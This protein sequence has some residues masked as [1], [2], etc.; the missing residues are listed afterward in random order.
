MAKKKVTKIVALRDVLDKQFYDLK[1]G[2]FSLFA[3]DNF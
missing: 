1:S 3:D 2:G